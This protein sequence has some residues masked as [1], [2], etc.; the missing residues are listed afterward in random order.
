L[1]YTIEF[2]TFGGSGRY[3][4]LTRSLEIEAVNEQTAGMKLAHAVRNLLREICQPESF[5]AAGVSQDIFYS[6][7]DILCEHAQMDS[8][9]ATSR[10][11]P[12][13]DEMHRLFEYAYDGKVVDF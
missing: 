9:I 6:K 10:R 5:S 11:S 13:F 3:L 12:S 4:E 1:P 2:T 8:S 7:L